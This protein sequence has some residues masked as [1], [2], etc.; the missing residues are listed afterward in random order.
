VAGVL[1]VHGKAAAGLL[2]DVI[3]RVG[4]ERQAAIVGL[5]G[6]TI[7]GVANGIVGTALV[8]AL[9]A[10]GAFVLAGL[11]AAFLLAIA[12]FMVAVLQLPT[13]LLTVPIALAVLY[14]GDPRW[15]VFLLLWGLLVVGLVDNFLRPYLISQGTRLPI[16]LIFVGVIGGLLAYGIL[17]L[18]IGPVILA[19]AWTLLLDWL[20]E[21]RTAPAGT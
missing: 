5:A 20:R 18:F 1:F 21:G 12:V 8:Q 3:A 7:R 13:Q 19:V 2:E 10:L 11:P 17:G 14:A 15:G 16:L 9:L 4:G 6:R